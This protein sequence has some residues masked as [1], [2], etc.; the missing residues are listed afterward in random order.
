MR[1]ITPVLDYHLYNNVVPK[2]AN[3]HMTCGVILGD[4][5]TTLLSDSYIWLEVLAYVKWGS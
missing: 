5:Y 1:T 4:D 2:D 3:T